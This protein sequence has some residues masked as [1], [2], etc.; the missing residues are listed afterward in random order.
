M[1]VLAPRMVDEHGVEAWVG[2][3][4]P[5]VRHQTAAWLTPLARF[6]DTTTWHRAVGHDVRAHRREARGRLG[7]RRRDVDPHGRLPRC[8]RLRRALLHELRGGRPPAPAPRSWGASRRA[9]LPHRRPRR[10]RVLAVGV[11]ATLA[12]PGAADLR[13]QVG[14]AAQALQ[15]ALTAA[16][17]ANLRSTR[18]GARPGGTCTRSRSPAH[19][20]SMIRGEPMTRALILSEHDLD[21]WGERFRAG[22][23][24]RGPALRRGR[25]GRP[26]LVALTGHDARGRPALGQ[27]PRRRRA[28]SRFPDRAGLRGAA[29]AR[30]SDVV[31][32]L[33]EQQGAA[34]SV[35][36]RAT[37]CRRTARRP[38][39]SGRAGWPRSFAIGRPGPAAAPGKRAS[40]A[41]T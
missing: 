1:R 17:A 32:A 39:S 4:F 13:R 33:L 7:G 36:R 21:A 12:R 30:R 3:D 9:P 19:E 28:P 10:R 15:A 26:G 24:A 8:R 35:L 22:R 14:V 38:W 37:G 31:I 40:T 20:L 16:T 34:A 5:R 27:A 23:G 6:R 18:R 11:A 29:A 2:R 25:A 41:P